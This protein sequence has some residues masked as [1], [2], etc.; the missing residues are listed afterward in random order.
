M[1]PA[2][3]RP[4]TPRTRATIASGSWRLAIDTAAIQ[5]ESMSSHRRSEPSWPPQV[6]ANRNGVGS[7]EFEWLA[8]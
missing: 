5:P 6:A 2:L 7:F 1:N 3:T 4:S 8:T